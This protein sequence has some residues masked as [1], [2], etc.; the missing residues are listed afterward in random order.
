M[1]ED[2]LHGQLVHALEQAVQPVV[3]GLEGYLQNASGD[4]PRAVMKCLL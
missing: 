1:Q 4:R 3:G 2:L